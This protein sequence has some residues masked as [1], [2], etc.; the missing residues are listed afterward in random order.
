MKETIEE[1]N[2]SKKK[3]KEEKWVKMVVDS[4]ILAEHVAQRKLKGKQKQIS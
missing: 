3:D 2:E 4:Q 1:I